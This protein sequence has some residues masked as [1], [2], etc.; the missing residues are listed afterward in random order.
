MQNKRPRGLGRLLGCTV[1]AG[2]VRLAAVKHAA[3]E[4][5]GPAIG[6]RGC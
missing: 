5:V 6:V 1:M 4:C 2:A 3:A